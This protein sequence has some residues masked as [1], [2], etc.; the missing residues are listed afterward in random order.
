MSR[1]YFVEN[2]KLLFIFPKYLD[3]LGW[4]GLRWSALFEKYLRQVRTSWKG[5]A[6]CDVPFRRL[7]PV[8]Q[9]LTPFRDDKR[10]LGKIFL[11]SDPCALIPFYDQLANF[12][13]FLKFVVDG[14][15]KFEI[16]TQCK[17]VLENKLKLINHIV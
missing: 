5:R 11:Q 2:N 10:I 14:I 17:N 6:L 12:S 4:S 8:L 3:L 9:S 15:L 1:S 13:P 16:S 7:W